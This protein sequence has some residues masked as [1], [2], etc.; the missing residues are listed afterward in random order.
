V[1]I[2]II[3]AE[4][5]LELIPIFVELEQYYFGNDAASESELVSYVSEKMFSNQSG[6]NVVAVYDESRIVGFSTYTIMYPAPKLSGQMYMK[7]LFVSS[8]ARGR[9][10]GIAL[11][12]HLALVAM[13]SGCQRLD[14]TAE[15]TNPKAGQFYQSIGAALVKEKEYYRFEGSDLNDFAEPL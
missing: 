4:N 11:M 6:I 1:E 10:V 2:K 12:K 8:S 15:N 9:G 3:N 14:W 5:C 7:D 13:D